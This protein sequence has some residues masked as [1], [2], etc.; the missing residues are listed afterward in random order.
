MRFAGN[1]DFHGK[2]HPDGRMRENAIGVVNNR[3][4]SIFRHK[5]EPM[6]M[7]GKICLLA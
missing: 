4:I 7:N 5:M 3:L 2:L 1:G 6:K